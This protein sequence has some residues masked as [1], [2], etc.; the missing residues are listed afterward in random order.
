MNKD[1]IF[2]GTDEVASTGLKHLRANKLE[3]IF[4][5]N[6]FVDIV[7]EETIAKSGCQFGILISYGK[8]ISK[9]I[10]SL[11]PKGLLNIH[12]SLLP[13]LRGPS[14]IKSAILEGLAVTGVSIMLLD[15]E[16]D[17]GPILTQREITLSP[18]VAREADLREALLAEGARLLKQILPDYLSGNLKPIEQDHIKATYTRKFTAEDGLIETSL[19]LGQ[20]RLDEVVLADRKVRALASEPGTYCIFETTTGQKRLKILEAKIEESKLVPTLVQPAGKRPMDWA[21]F[22]RGNKLVS[23]RLL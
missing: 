6:K 18:Q 11:F 23:S 14:P 21:A 20:S 4:C 12:P 15:T 2:F 1:F 8:I 5:V 10:M 22:L 16:I 3:P 17:H 9:K 19:I 13:L 7:M